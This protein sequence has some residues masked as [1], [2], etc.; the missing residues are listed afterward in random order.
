THRAAEMFESLGKLDAAAAAYEDARAWAHAAALWKRIGSFARA[1]ELFARVER[2]YDAAQCFASDGQHD[3]AG[4]AF[5]RADAVQFA[6][7]AYATAGDPLRAGELYL[8]AGLPEAA[9]EMLLDVPADADSYLDA[10]ILLVPMLLDVGEDEEAERRLVE[11]RDRREELERHTLLYVQARGLE[12][13][14]NLSGAARYYEMTIA[15]RRSYRDALD[16]LERLRERLAAAPSLRESG[17]LGA[18]GQ[19]HGASTQR[20]RLHPSDAET[21]EISAPAGLAEPQPAADPA[22]TPS[23]GLSM[24]AEPE[25]TLHEPIEPWWSGSEFHRATDDRDGREVFAVTFSLAEVVER[26]DGFRY[27]M[28]QVAALRHK[29]VLELHET[30]LARDRVL[31]LYEPFDGRTLLS[32]LGDDED[33]GTEGALHVI[34][35]LCEALHDAHKLGVTHQWLSPRTVLVRDDRR[36]KL[37][38]LGLREFLADPDPTAHAYLS[39][40]VV[41]N[42]VIGPAS[43]I[44]SLGLLALELLGAALPAVHGT[45]YDPSAVRWP[46]EVAERVPPPLRR[47]LVACLAHDPLARPTI[48]ELAAAFAALGFVDGQVLGGRYEITGELGRGGMSR[49]YRA[50]DRELGGEVAIKTVLDARGE[51]EE[52]LLREV[53]ISRRISHPR[54]VRVHDLGRFPG[55]IFII[56]ELLEGPGLDEVIERDAPLSLHRTRRLMIEIAQALGEAHRLGIV[57]R[58]L[59]PG[60]VILVDDHAKVLDFG[61]ARSNDQSNLDLTRTGEVIGSPLFMAPEQIQGRPLDGTCDLY[62]LGVIAFTMLTGREPFNAD[63]PTAV[64]LQ[65]LHEAPP[66]IRAFRSSLPASWIELLHDLLAKKPEDR[67]ADAETLIHRLEALDVVE[68]TAA[69]SEPQLGLDDT[70]IDLDAAPSKVASAASGPEAQAVESKEQSSPAEARSL[71]NASPHRTAGPV[72]A[73]DGAS[74]PSL[75]AEAPST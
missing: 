59:K 64:V 9:R 7:D 25:V 31:L 2:H 32:R 56:M 36:V 1:G 57:H 18:A 67:P 10:S 40:E 6:A 43:D 61:I 35:Q 14:G 50:I 13:R 26:I 44:F 52:R 20:V 68:G 55:G 42:G 15:R 17:R 62:A 38:G 11:L 16:R 23:H 12:A 21:S 39:P 71:Q 19:S 34:I 60:N 74:E 51:N 5:L 70:E 54:V 41:A 63:T 30:L 8:E 28:R 37:A 27:V 48:A 75:D 4:E 73:D 72:A 29:A 33:F 22:A 46:P 45:E 49:V 65:H 53:Q 24:V 58:D 66:D 47:I 69:A 3:R